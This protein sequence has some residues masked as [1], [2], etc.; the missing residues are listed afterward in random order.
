MIIWG[1]IA[2]LAAFGA[3][4]MGAVA[5]AMFWA[6]VGSVLIAYGIHRNKQKQSQ[7][8]QQTVI[9]NNYAAPPSADST[10]TPSPS[11]SS[12]IKHE[13]V[14]E[15][16]K[17]LDDRQ[18]RIDRDRQRFVRLSFP[19]A[20]VTFQNEDKTDRQ[21]ILREI[22]LNE[23]GFCDVWFDE[24]EDLGEDSGIRV[25]TELGC[26]GFLRRSDKKEVH[27]FFDKM[28]HSRF[29]SVERFENDDGQRI[30]RADVCINMDREDPDQQWY[31]DEL[32]K[33]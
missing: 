12:G 31:F 10:P 8:Q 16:T 4:G 32:P 6:A 27:R 13:S 30:Y 5:A 24:D 3:L 21:Q 2:I 28:T 29:L 9:V 33:S 25:M 1:A 23:D 18:A 22:A 11:G 26:V 7:S 14:E 17:R 19:V 15:F 20:G